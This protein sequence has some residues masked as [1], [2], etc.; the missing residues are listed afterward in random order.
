MKNWLLLIMTLALV[1]PLLGYSPN[2]CLFLG[3]EQSCI[4]LAMGGHAIGNVNIWHDSPLSSLSNPASGAFREGISWG[5]SEKDW[6]K[7]TGL[8][9]T[10]SSSLVNLGW[11]GVSFT[12]PSY[13]LKDRSGVYFDL[14]M[15]GSGSASYHAYDT[16]EVY[17]FAFDAVKLTGK[18]TSIPFVEEH[19]SL[20]GGMNYLGIESHYYPPSSPYG[21]GKG[22]SWDIGTAGRFCWEDESGVNLEAVAAYTHRN[23]FDNKID[24]GNGMKDAIWESE[25]LGYALGASLSAEKLLGNSKLIFCENLLSARYLS[26]TSNESGY[27]SK[28]Y[29]GELGLLDTFF[30]RRGRYD[31]YQGDVI[32]ATWGY[33]VNLHYKD[34]VSV[35]WNYAKY[36]GGNLTPNQEARD[37]NA[38]INLMKVGKV[39]SSLLGGR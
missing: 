26:S 25:S 2:S 12:L 17:G 31:D 11:D 34:L 32:G 3:M 13:K 30:L 4:N 38:N 19:F 14:G 36:P 29:G 28:G 6:L 10:T 8:G 37:I 16:A 39:L 7:A 9:Y 1:I 27:I 20:A 23:A 33:G 22:E 5:L 21:K 35:S 24:W 15:A 18:F